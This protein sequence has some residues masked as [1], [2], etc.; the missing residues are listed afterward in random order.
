M[1]A[2]AEFLKAINPEASDDLADRVSVELRSLVSG[3]TEAAEEVQLMKKE[4]GRLRAELTTH[5]NGVAG[6]S[7]A[8]LDVLGERARQR[9]FE[10]YDD[11]HDDGHD[12][13]SLLAAAM[14]Y[15]EGALLQGTTGHSFDDTPP[16]SWPWDPSD[17]KSKDLRR[18]LVFMAA[19]TIAEIERIDRADER[20]NA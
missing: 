4:I 15:G 12:D 17:W 6:A 10:G 14:A 8:G 19:L 13:F 11:S 3:D 18:M 7:R 20:K 5:E 1:S 2:I 16:P 9:R